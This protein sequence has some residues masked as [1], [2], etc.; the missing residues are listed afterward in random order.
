MTLFAGP[1]VKCP[2]FTEREVLNAVRH[3]DYYTIED[4]GSTGGIRIQVFKN[5]GFE[6]FIAND[7]LGYIRCQDNWSFPSKGNGPI[8]TGT[9]WYNEDSG[10]TYE[11]AVECV[12]ALE[13][14]PA[15]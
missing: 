11:E 3:S 2:C 10:M 13:A 14:I 15:P 12:N 5:A 8:K 7:T 9:V 6:S 4:L 1:P